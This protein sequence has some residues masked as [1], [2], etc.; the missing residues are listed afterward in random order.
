MATG[1]K[2]NNRTTGAAC[3][4][5]R[6]DMWWDNDNEIPDNI[7]AYAAMISHIDAMVGLMLG[8]LTNTVSPKTPGLSLVTTAKCYLTTKALPKATPFRGSS[9]VPFMIKPPIKDVF[10]TPDADNTPR[11]TANNRGLADLMP[12]VL[13]IAGVTFRK[14]STAVRPYHSCHHKRRSVSTCHWSST[15]T[16]ASPMVVTVIAG[17]ATKSRNAL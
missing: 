12:T 4:K 6:T 7:R 11:M 14:A 9:G 3:L 13:D 10:G 8:C 5:H 17:S 15:K 16:S 1:A 2:R